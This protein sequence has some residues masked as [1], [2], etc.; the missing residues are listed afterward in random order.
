LNEKFVFPEDETPEQAAAGIIGW[1]E[2]RLSWASHMTLPLYVSVFRKMWR[3]KFGDES[4]IPESLKERT[5]VL[6]RE[7]KADWD[8]AVKSSEEA[9]A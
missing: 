4:G 6:Y 1:L 8:A 7:C 5:R 9:H 2:R 3:E